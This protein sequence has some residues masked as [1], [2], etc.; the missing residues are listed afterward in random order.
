MFSC[1]SQTACGVGEMAEMKCNE[2]CTSKKRR[3][4]FDK[5]GGEEERLVEPNQA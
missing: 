5:S 1:S 4:V 3:V 2:G